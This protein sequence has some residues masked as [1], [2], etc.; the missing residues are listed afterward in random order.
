MNAKKLITRAISGLVYCLLMVGGVLL[1][2]YG[3]V[4][5]GIILSSLACI[6]FAKISHELNHGNI[7]LLIIDIAG[8]WCLALT[9]LNPAICLFWVL[10]MLVRL[11]AQL[12]VKNPTPLK[13][14]SHSLMSQIYIGFPM[15][16]MSMID[17]CWDSRLILLVFVI[18]WAND[19]GA[20]LVGSAIGKH[21]L[22]ERI[23]PKK[24][25]EGFIGGV[26][27]SI[28]CAVAFFYLCPGVF[29]ISRT[30]SGIWLT[31]GFTVVVTV[32]GTW[33]DLVES[34]IK[35]TLHI[36][37]SGNI[38]PGHGGILDRI[39]SLLLALPAA[40]LYLVFINFI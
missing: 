33:G 35:R 9:A 1:G 25:W 40:F 20:F 38:I 36:K 6:E 30:L 5:L 23:S 24:S 29:G 17:F 37:D 19:T 3:V 10:I 15:L 13:D 4:A 39:D 12:Y 26:A 32:F 2:N 27:V 16:A 14:L 31:I 7:P 18:I 22:F 8:C 28:G 34:L 21:R 11:I